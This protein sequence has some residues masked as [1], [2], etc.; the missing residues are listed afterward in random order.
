[1]ATK[2]NTMKTRII[3][4][5]FLLVI[6]AGCTTTNI[7]IG[8]TISAYDAVSHKIQL[9]DSKDEALSILLPTQRKLSKYYSKRP[10]QYLKN[11][12]KVEIYY[13]RSGWQSDGL[14]TDDEFTPYVF[15]EDKLIAIGWAS[16]G[17]PKTQGQVAPTINVKQETVVR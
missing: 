8:E 6:L 2:G 16:I 13:M 7:N 4:S 10:D 14:T 15:V 9:G 17:G 5:L 3:L 12:K 1:M 11:G